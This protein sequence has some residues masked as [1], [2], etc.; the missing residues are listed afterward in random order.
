MRTAAVLLLAA[1]AGARADSSSAF[2]PDGGPLR[3]DSESALA[4]VRRHCGPCHH[5]DLPDHKPEAVAVFD[6]TRA[7]WHLPMTPEQLKKAP[8]R[9]RASDLEQRLFGEWVKA[10]LERREAR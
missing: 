3:N 7:D 8:G 2:L 9:L 10:E 6:T 1:C 4:I 5:S